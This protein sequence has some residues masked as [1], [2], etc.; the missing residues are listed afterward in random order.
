[1][2]TEKHFQELE[3]AL[4]QAQVEEEAANDFSRR[5][6]E[7]HQEL[8]TIK[9]RAKAPVACSDKSDHETH[10]SIPSAVL[11][12]SKEDLNRLITGIVS[13]VVSLFHHFLKL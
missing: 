12:H 11:P 3:L 9:A 7:I 2:A 4:Q 13:K 5:S 1:M 8:K 6:L 10:P